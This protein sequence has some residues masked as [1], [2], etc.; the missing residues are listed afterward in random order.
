MSDH[1][2][3]EDTRDPLIAIETEAAL[4]GAMLVEN[5]LIGEYSDRLTVKD[6]SEPVHGRIWSALLRFHA[7]GVTASPVTMKPVFQNDPSAMG[8]DYLAKLADS[9]ALTIGAEDFAAQLVDF[10]SRRRVREAAKETLRRL[11]EDFET[12]VEEIVAPVQEAAWSTGEGDDVESSDG[13]GMVRRVLER[14]ERIRAGGGK[15]GA[16]N[17]FIDDLNAG[18]GPLEPGTYLVLAGRPGMGKSALASS[19]ALGY[20][21]NGHPVLYLQLEMSQDQQA[22]RVVSDAS[23]AMGRGVP[24]ADIRG[25]KLDAG[26]INWLGRVEERMALLPITYRAVGHCSVRRIESLVA[27]QAAL[28]SAAGKPLEV[29][30]IDYLGLISAQDSQGREIDDDRKRMNVVSKA[31]LGIAKRYGVAIIALAQLNR[32]VEARADKRPVLSDLKE[33]GNLEQDAD[34]VMMVYRGEYYLLQSKP[35]AGEKDVKG[36][37]LLEQWEVDYEAVRGKIDLLIP[38]NRHDQGR[39]RQA[40]FFGKYYAIRGSDVSEFDDPLE[41]ALLV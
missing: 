10:A 5:A 23:L 25:D 3:P 29:V 9:P 2:H 40:K 13:A 38:K 22:M 14:S 27:R 17:A 6:F 20:A 34:I 31:V 8:G 15:T 19:A 35:K 7:K 32:G 18:I 30:V 37:E 26:Q 28:C 39:P 24:H 16:T 41:T 4:L 33:S 36:K 1:G 11:G 12:P 21:A